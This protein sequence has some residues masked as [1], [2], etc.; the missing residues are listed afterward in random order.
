[1]DFDDLAANINSMAKLLGIGF[2]VGLLCG[3]IGGIA[4]GVMV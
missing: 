4:I 1:V 2:A 3:L